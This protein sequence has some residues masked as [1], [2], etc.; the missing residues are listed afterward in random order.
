VRPSSESELEALLAAG[1]LERDLTERLGRYA[2]LV[3]E[4][5]Q[6][7][8][9]TGAKTPAE[10][11]GHILD[12]LSLVR[13]VREPYVDIGSGGGLPA[14]P[15]AIV[16]GIPVTMVESSAKKARF[17]ESALRR[18]E[19]EGTVVAERAE[20][21]G[22]WPD[23]RERFASGTA[24]ALASAPVVAEL[25]LPLIAPGGAAF[26]QRGALPPA[27]RHA[28][29]DAALML[30]GAFDE[31]RPLEGTRRIVIVGKRSRTPERFPRR[32]GVPAKRPLCM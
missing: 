21:A 12:S 27:E 13:F 32:P 14:I 9:L 3:L 7:F 26:L 28:L 24:R 25:L 19:L 20:V 8:N 17:L 16:A 10:I 31:E 15:V 5:N 1:G 4:A 30:G 6:R 22:H 29:A 2:Q 23:L 18:L 11:A